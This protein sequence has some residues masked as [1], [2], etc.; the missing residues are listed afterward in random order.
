MTPLLNGA[1][2]LVCGGRWVLRTLLK[3]CRV[4]LPSFGPPH[5]ISPFCRAGMV[6]RSETLTSKFSA[7]FRVPPFVDTQ[8]HM[9]G[10]VFNHSRP[11]IYL[12]FFTDKKILKSKILVQSSAVLL[13]GYLCFPTFC[14]ERSDLLVPRVVNFFFQIFVTLAKRVFKLSPYKS[15]NYL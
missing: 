2:R 3:R 9:V 13:F 15:T 4:A 11:T 10:K 14:L 8:V 5:S 7:S 1:E 12:F 6:E